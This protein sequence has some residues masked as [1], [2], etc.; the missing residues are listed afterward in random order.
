MEIRRQLTMPPAQAGRRLDQALAD[1]LP[2]FSRSRL[3]VWIEAG[4]VQVDGVQR[5]PRYRLTGGERVELQAHLDVADEV[6]AQPLPLAVIYEDE[7]LLVVAKPAGLVVHPGAGNPDQT[8]QN[9]LLHHRPA[10]ATL[11][12]AGIIHRLDKDTS[13][14]LVVAATTRAHRQLVAALE[15]RE[16]SRRYQA[17]VRGAV[18]AGATVDAPIGR[19]PVRRTRMA[20]RS[21]GRAAR[22]HY[23]V[24]ERF[25][26]F[27]LLDVRL[28]TGRTHQI[29]VHLAHVHWP[30]VG[31]PV[32]GGRLGLPPGCTAELADALKGFKRQALH[33]WQLGFAHPDNGEALQ[34]EAPLPDDFAQLLATVR[35]ADPLPA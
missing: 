29:R 27:T 35:A 32:Y 8:L 7:S 13:G 12:R 6:I 19:H 26:H 33:A 20:V 22:T 2:D 21:D 5:P 23:R 9:A 31:D 24:L 10:L 1:E 25:G 34:F 11:P 15:A 16:I 18:T 14:L 28:E 17:L 4:C 3:K 30:I